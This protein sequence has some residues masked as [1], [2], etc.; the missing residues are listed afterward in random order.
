MGRRGN[1]NIFGPILSKEEAASSFYVD[2]HL[3]LKIHSFECKIC[4][5]LSINCGY[6]KLFIIPTHIKILLSQLFYL[7]IFFFQKKKNPPIK[8]YIIVILWGRHN[9]PE[10][11]YNWRGLESKKKQNG[12]TA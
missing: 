4:F 5:I 8:L 12:G 2:F 6:I 10:F 3:K 1:Q 11:V 7:V 9:R